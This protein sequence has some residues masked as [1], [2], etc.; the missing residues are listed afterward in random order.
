MPQQRSSGAPSSGAPQ[1]SRRPSSRRPDPAEVTD[2]TPFNEFGALADLDFRHG[3]F[4][5]G[6]VV[7]HAPELDDLADTDNLVAIRLERRS[8]LPERFETADEITEV[9]PRLGQHRKVETGPV[10][11]RV[12]VAAM[13][14]GAAAAAAY[15]AL[16]PR[17]ASEVTN[18]VV[19]ADPASHSEGATITGTSKGMQLVA[20][21]PALNV[22]GHNEELAKGA[23]FA[24]ERA[25]REA[26]LARPL[27]VKPTQGIFTSGYGYRWGALHGGIDIA[28]PIGTPIYAVSDG[29]VIEAGPAAGYGALVK[30][31]HNDGTVT[32]Y[33]HINT[34]VV[35]TGQQVMA[36][37]QIAT[38]GNRGNST[39]PHCHFE[40]MPDGGSRIDPVPWLAARGVSVGSY[41]G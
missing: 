34:W 24:Q 40:V 17:Q 33:G 29:V 1:D 32:L 13:A 6:A 2:I 9:M 41:V 14:A 36:G 23:A 26:R 35:S 27:F 7:L 12:L 4:D 37:D 18:T 16:T 30:I 38:V 22:T 8:D 39:G 31:R 5:A 25:E 20:M 15:T 19:A 21:T 11:G 10:K 28:A 3:A